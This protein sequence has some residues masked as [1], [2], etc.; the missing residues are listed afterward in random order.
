MPPEGGNLAPRTFAAA[1]VLAFVSTACSDSGSGSTA[2]AG[3]GRPVDGGSHDGTTAGQT[4]DDDAAPTAGCT[5]TMTTPLDS[6]D[7]GVAAGPTPAELLA[8]LG[9]AWTNSDGDTFDVEPG[10]NATLHV[11]TGQV[12]HGGGT[13]PPSC[14]YYTHVTVTSHI[15]IATQNGQLDESTEVELEL[16]GNIAHFV[17]KFPLE[18][19]H[20]SYRPSDPVVEGSVLELTGDFGIG[21]P[22]WDLS[23]STRVESRQVG[24]GEATGGGAVVGFAPFDARL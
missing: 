10:A 6:L 7:A 15:A 1:C 9:G 2:T 8:Q 13:G 12:R 17:A 23:G 11:F 20:G 24:P 19:L 4:D 18:S 3:D 22:E 21:G 14:D 5:E 16:R